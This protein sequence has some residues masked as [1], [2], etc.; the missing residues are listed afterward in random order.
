MLPSP[1]GVDSRETKRF[2]NRRR[3]FVDLF[4]VLRD[5]GLLALHFFGERR[6][7]LLVVIGLLVGAERGDAKQGRCDE[8]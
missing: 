8:S 3:L 2:P 5:R 6:D 7:L 4:L 1:A